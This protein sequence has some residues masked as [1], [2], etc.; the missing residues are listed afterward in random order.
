ML[1]WSDGGISSMFLAAHYPECVR[2]LVVWG[3]NAFVTDED[4]KK[5]E[6]IRD[7]TSW[8]KSTIDNYL[9][10]YKKDYFQNQFDNWIDA[11]KR[12]RATNDGEI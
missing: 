6:E 8:K 5:F 11:M 2:K 9:Q 1:G 12:I 10:V 3:A 7:V 4:V